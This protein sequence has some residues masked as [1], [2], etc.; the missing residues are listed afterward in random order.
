VPL[1][2]V[3]STPKSRLTGKPSYE[4][5]RSNT[6]PGKE[7]QEG[8]RGARRCRA[9]VPAPVYGLLPDELGH[10]QDGQ[11]GPIGAPEPEQVATKRRMVGK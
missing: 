10:P 8:A 2:F 6:A 1:D 5:G 11:A 3:R 7:A 4:P 9:A